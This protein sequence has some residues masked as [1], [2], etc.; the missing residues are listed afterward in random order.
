MCQVAVNGSIE[1]APTIDKVIA[2]QPHEGVV[3]GAA[4]KRVGEH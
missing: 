4:G 2:G 3:V 1:A